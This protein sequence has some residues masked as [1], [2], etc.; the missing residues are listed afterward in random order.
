MF[1]FPFAGGGASIFREWKA[2]LPAAVEV[3]P[4]Q[5]P[6][7]ENRWSEAPFTSLSSLVDALINALEPLF[8]LPFVFFGHSMGALISFEL[9]KLL[10]RRTD[11]APVHL[12]ISGAR[13][14][15]I[16]DRDPPIHQLPDS[17]FVKE[18]QRLNGMPELV[19]QNSELMRL[20]LPTIRADITLC[21]T[22][23]YF[24][25]EPL[26]CP[27][28]AYGGREDRKVQRE[29]LAGWNAHTSAGFSVRAFPGD[30]FY[31]TSARKLL[32][33][34]LSAELS[35]ILMRMNDQQERTWN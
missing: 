13:A 31:L 20:V 18:L 10:R 3:H 11:K 8:N 24:P 17:E 15:Q 32:L 29:H 25:E 2:D 5:L 34:A 27:I 1:C 19:L 4:I 26:S 35:G 23:E 12:F 28:T 21:E 16:P 33:R 14:P 9:A 7:R 22:H 6:G 30:H